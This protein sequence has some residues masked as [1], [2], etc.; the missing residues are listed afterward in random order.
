[1]NL[2]TTKNDSIA[3]AAER[4]LSESEAIA[5]K[6]YKIK[7]KNSQGYSIVKVLKIDRGIVIYKKENAPGTMAYQPQRMPQDDF[8]EL[9]V[10]S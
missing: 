1:M 2:F 4:V 10:G 5:G 3:E 9:I 6:T 8:E 7:M